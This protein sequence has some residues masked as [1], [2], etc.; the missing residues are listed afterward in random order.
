M[1]NVRA[2]ALTV[3]IAC[4]AVVLLAGNAAWAA[5]V[6]YTIDPA[7]STFQLTGTFD[8]APL[9]EQNPGSSTVGYP[10]TLQ[11]DVDRAAG[12]LSFPTVVLHAGDQPIDQL[13]AAAGW[14]GANYGFNALGGADF[15]QLAVRSLSLFFQANSLAFNAG[16]PDP[17]TL[18]FFVND[19]EL[20]YHQIARDHD[21]IIDLHGLGGASDKAVGAITLA[22]SGNVETLTIPLTSTFSPNVRDTG[23]PINFTLTG[24][25]VAT[26]LV[27]EPAS[28]AATCLCVAFAL[29]RNRG[30]ANR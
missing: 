3:V 7:A 4:T 1:R 28:G 24:Q 8:G 19:G 11:V 18:G 6:P 25:L 14:T 29:R 12:K 17:N 27:P 21:E 20:R 23:H 13:P 22:T 10:G 16:V 2:S 5:P 26:R 9:N 15:T 30:L